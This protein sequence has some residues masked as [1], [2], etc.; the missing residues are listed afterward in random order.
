[1]VD[2]PDSKNDSQDPVP[3]KLAAVK[4]AA[5]PT[6][7]FDNLDALRKVA[8]PVIQKRGI[9]ANVKVGTPDSDGYFR[10]HTDPSL[11]LSVGVFKLKGDKDR[12]VYYVTPDMESHPIV[13][14]RLRR[15]LLVP[16]FSWPLREIGLWPVPLDTEGAG[17][18]WWES[19]RT[20]YETAKTQ[21]TQMVAD[22]GH[23]KVSIAEGTDGNSIPE[24]EWPP[25]TLNELLKLGFKSKII[26]DEDHPVMKRLRG[27]PG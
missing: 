6:S 11:T 10:V 7:V 17:G 5:D 1:M 14:P 24:P 25:F 21:W 18:P 12:T 4:P 15:V 26:N 20:A 22:D 19:A 2:D 27:I 3:P 9:L 13:V 23:Y 16:T 8:S